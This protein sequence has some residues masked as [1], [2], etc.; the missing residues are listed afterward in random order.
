MT[1]CRSF[2]LL[3]GMFTVWGQANP[4]ALSTVTRAMAH[5]DM[6]LVQNIKE[7]NICRHRSTIIIHVKGE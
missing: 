3:R 5:P 6:Y 2:T 4:I 1:A 7:T